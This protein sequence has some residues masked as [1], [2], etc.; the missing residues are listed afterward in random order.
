MAVGGGGLGVAGVVIYLVF[1]LLGGGGAGDAKLMGAI[2]ACLGL[3]DGLWA[4]C[5]VILCGGVMGLGFA[6]WKR[7]ARPVLARVSAMA[8]GIAATLIAGGR[9]REAASLLPGQGEM[10]AMRYGPVVFC[11]VCLARGGTIL[12]HH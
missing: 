3:H 10:V 2:G 9:W 11:G 8:G 5:A 1:A 7:R 6:F 4:L 12:W